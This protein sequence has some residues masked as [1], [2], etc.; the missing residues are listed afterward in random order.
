MYKSAPGLRYLRCD[1]NALCGGR[2][3]GEPHAGRVGQKLLLGVIPKMTGS[4]AD[5]FPSTRMRRMRRDEFS[6]RLMR[7]THLSTDALI[8]PIFVVEG[9]RQR[10][11]VSSMPGIERLSADELLRECADL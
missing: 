10:Q 4:R 7:E 11:A 1:I 9:T 2:R 8:Y 6:R 3:S 5:S